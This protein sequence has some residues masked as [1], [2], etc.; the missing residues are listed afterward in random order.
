MFNI[1]LYVVCKAQYITAAV[2]ILEM[3]NWAIQRTQASNWPQKQ[4]QQQQ[5]E[6]Q[7]QQIQ[8]TH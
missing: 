8:E 3:G 1:L 2:L 7:P 6:Q 5:Q 4:Q